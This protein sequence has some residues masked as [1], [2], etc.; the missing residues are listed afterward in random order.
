[1]ISQLKKFGI[2]ASVF[3]MLG[4]GAIGGGHAVFAQ[5]SSTPPAASASTDAA[6][7]AAYKSFVAKLTANLGLSDTTKVDAA[8]KTTLKQMVDEA[9]SAGNISAKEQ[10]SLKAEID[11]SADPANLLNL[12]EISGGDHGHADENGQDNNGQN[13]GESNDGNASAANGAATNP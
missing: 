6:S 9:F 11:S 7:Q 8:I 10:A 5:S 4:L 3:A 2:G 13:D 1:M 12:E